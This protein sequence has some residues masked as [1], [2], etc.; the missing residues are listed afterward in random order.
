MR[1]LVRRYGHATATAIA[2]A[3]TPAERR[4]LLDALANGERIPTAEWNTP[5]GRGGRAASTRVLKSL[6]AKGLLLAFG[7]TYS[8]RLSPLG[9]EVARSVT[10]PPHG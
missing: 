10:P 9:V 1:H 4:A 3:L 5:S 7:A 8:N 6:W 2:A